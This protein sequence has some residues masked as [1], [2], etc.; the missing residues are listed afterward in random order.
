MK[1]LILFGLMATS[2]V[3]GACASKPGSDI[4]I[5]PAYVDR[6]QYD[7][8]LAECV[9]L[10]EQVKQKAG[11]RAAKGAVVGG[12]IG[13]ILG[14]KRAAEKVL[15]LAQYQAEQGAREKPSVRKNEL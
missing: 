13:A 7:Q 11:K 5:D 15:V 4:I 14:G 8:D 6:A 3:L 10:S 1:N 2:I 9:R 12:L